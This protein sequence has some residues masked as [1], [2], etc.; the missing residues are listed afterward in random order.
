MTGQSSSRI[1]ISI[2]LGLLF[3]IVLA[4]VIAPGDVDAQTNPPTGAGDWNIYDVTTISNQ[5][6]TLQG[7][8]NVYSGG[9]LT[10]TNVDLIMAHAS[11][12]GKVFR[13]R[14]NAQLVYNGGSISHSGATS[15]YKFIVDSGA[16]VTMDGVEVSDLWHNPSTTSSALQGGMQIQSNSVTITDCTFKDNDRVAM[17]ITSASPTIKN[18]TFMRSSYFSYYRSSNYIYREAFG[19]VVIDG[20]PRIEG[21]LFTELGDYSTAFTDAGSYSYTYLRLNGMGVYSVRGSPKIT[22]SLFTDIGRM[23]TSSSVYMYVPAVGRYVYFYFWSQ[24]Y[25][26]CIKAQDPLALE[27]TGCNFSF[28]YQGYYSYTSQA[29]GVYQSGGS[30]SIKNNIWWS[31]GG[32][33]V[34]IFAGNVIMRDNEMYDFYYYGLYIN[35]RGTVTVMNNIF[36]GTAE[37]RNIRNEVGIYI[38]QGSGSIDIRNINIT[39]CQR[40][41]YVSDTPNSKFYDIYINNCSKKVYANA[42]TVSCYNVTISRADIELGWNSAEVNIYYRLTVLVTWQN[43]SPVPNAIVQIFNESEGLLKANR[44]DATGVMP[45]LTMLQTKLKGTSNSQ[46][47]IVNSPLKISAY[48]NA[49]ES[50]MYTVTYDKNTFFQCILEDTLTPNVEIYGPFKDHAQNTTTLRLFGIAVDVGSGL[51][52][53][54]VSADDGN[55]WTRAN[56]SLRWNLSMDLLEGVYDMQ[57]RG[58]DLA[59]AISL[60]TIRNVTID[61]SKPWLIITSPKEQFIYTNQTTF[62]IIGQAEIG[63]AVFLNGEALKTQGGS[64]FTQISDQQEGLNTYEVMAVDHVGNRNISLLSIFQ[65]ITPP[66]LLVEHPP[67]DLVTNDRVLQISGLTEMGV[68]VT[69]NNLIV[70][71]ENGLFTMP[72]TLQE[73]VNKI[74]IQAVDLA[75]N[76]KVV[77][78][79]VIYDVTPPNVEMVYPVRDEA[80]NHST[81]LV[82]G[83][84]E[85][86]VAEVRVNQVPLTIRFGSFSKSFKLGEGENLI[87]VEVTDRAGNSI[88]RR[89]TLLLD[90]SSPV[91][92]LDGPID[93]MYSTEETVRVSGRVDVGSMV[94]VNDVEVEVSGG[95]FAYDAPLAETPPGSDPNLLV[96]VAYDEVGNTAVEKVRVYRDTHAPEFTVYETSPSITSDF[97]NI[98]GLVVDVDDVMTMTINEIPIQPNAK[99]YFV[100][101]VPLQMGVNVL[102]IQ[103]T[104]VAGNTH[105]EEGTIDRTTLEVSDTGIMGLG[106]SSW[107]MLVLFLVIGLAIGLILLYVLESRKGVPQ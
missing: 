78:F 86:D 50:K 83:N 2:G 66:I 64:F 23:H 69:I 18:S 29:F 84:V 46:T 16:T 43:G 36:N 20:A 25:R 59:G 67:E 31:N 24:D 80:V 102:V 55:T 74:T 47:S 89:Y 60:Y 62:T 94:T 100:A 7:N 42:A 87:L 82:S 35:G 90:T 27:V 91:L 22:D 85:A 99:G 6:I 1:G 13:V 48:A 10:L 88:S 17:V 58:V 65:D 8:L 45:P 96:I 57:V 95:F 92:V 34:A 105:E 56:G 97:T 11:L 101:Y 52:G 53:V 104:D 3:V 81:V 41:I 32:G 73:G 107:M 77:R 79:E 14:N 103:A 19:I 93:G 26:G 98:T 70:Q 40:A 12:G 106:D 51:D 5:R 15:T 21:C 39:F 44:A 4:M 75:K 61:L 54:E 63:A 72:M 30:S 33:G 68:L 9:K 28:N 71:V 38:S 76:H 37:F 49:I